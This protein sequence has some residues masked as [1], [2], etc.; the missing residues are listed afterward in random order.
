[1]SDFLTPE[2]KVL[3]ERGWLRADKIR[4]GDVLIT[5]AG[6]KVVTNLREL[7]LPVR[8]ENPNDF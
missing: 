8:T 4:V 7:S 5:Q 3:T 6:R 1:M 2:H